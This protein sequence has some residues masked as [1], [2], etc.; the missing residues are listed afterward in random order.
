MRSNRVERCTPR[1]LEW[2]A[3]PDVVTRSRSCVR[4]IR[5]PRICPGRRG[6]PRTTYGS[7]ICPGCAAARSWS[8]RSSTARTPPSTPT[9]CTPGRS[10]RR[11]T[12]RGP[13]SRRCRAGSA[14]A[15]PAGWRVCGENL[16]A[17]HSIAYDGPGE[18]VLRLLGLGRASAAWTGTG[19]C[20]SCAAGRSRAARAVAGR[21]STSGRCA[22]C[23]WTPRGR[24]GTSY[25]PSTASA[26]QEFGRRVAKWVRA[27]HVQTD[28]HW[29]HAAVVR[30]RAGSGRRAVG[31]AVGGGGRR[32]GAAGGG[33]GRTVARGDG[34]DA[35]GRPT[36]R[37]PTL[38]RLDALRPVRGRPAGRACWPPLLHGAPRARL[39]ARLAAAAGHAAG[40][41]GRR[42]GRAAPDAAPAVSRTRTGGPGWYG[43]RSPPT[44]GVLHAVARRRWRPDDAAG[45]RAGRLVRAARRGRRA[46]RR[47]AGAAA[48]RAAGGARRSR[49]GRGR[50]V[51]GRGAARRTR[52]GG[53]ARVEEAVA[54]TWRWRYGDVPP[55]DP[56]GR[57]VGQ[58]QEHLRRAACP[59]VDAY[60]VLDD[61]RAGPGLPGRPAGQRG[62]A[63]R[64]PR[65]ARRRAG[66]AAATV[67]WD[68]TSLNQQQRSPGARGRPPPRRPGHP[69]RGAGRRGGAGPAQRPRAPHP[70]PPR[71]ARPRSCTGSARRTPVRRTA[72]GTSAAGRRRRGHRRRALRRRDGR[73]R[74]AYQ[75]GDLPPGPLGRPVRPGAVRARASPSAGPRPSGS[76]CP[77][78]CPAATS[79][80]T[81]CCSSRRTASWSGTGP[82][83]WTGS[84]PPARGGCAS[85][86]CCGRRSSPP[87]PRTRGTGGRRLAAA[88]RPA[89]ARAAPA[90]RRPLR[91]LTWNTLWDRYD[92]DRHRH[93]PAPA[94]A[95]APP[96]AEA[97]A[98][99]IA[100]QEVEPALL[101]MLLREPLGAGAATRWAPTRR[102]RDV[103]DMRAAAAQPAARTG[104]RA[105]RARPAQGGH[106]RHRGDRRRPAGRRRHPPDQRPLRERCRPA[107]GRTGPARRGAGG[108][109]R[110]SGPAR[111]LQRRRRRTGEPRS[112]CGTPGPRCTAPDDRTP[113]FDPA[114]NPLAAVSSLSGRA[115]RLDRVLVRPGTAAGGPGGAGG[116]RPA[117]RTGC[118]SP[119]TTGSR[120]GSA[121]ARPTRST[122]DARR[123]TAGPADRPAEEPRGAARMA[124]RGSAAALPEGRVHLVGS[125]R[126]GCAPPGAD[127][128]LV[129]ALPGA[130]TAGGPGAGSRP[131][132]R[133]PTRIRA[134]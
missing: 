23:G 68:A 12:P 48:R 94:A 36:P 110:R 112:G 132:C 66:R 63:A 121:S 113:T 69:R 103:D 71:G 10:T 31:G 80:G 54:A 4:T 107:A 67:V 79:R 28:T 131:R 59:G 134:R 91:V 89:A 40:A 2:P 105:A 75:R 72:P 55:A 47:A 64:G 24:R 111:R 17:R 78:S 49:S 82:R 128:D 124:R 104:G 53:S 76:R 6:P 61:L 77:P 3:G 127:L 126:M 16:Y 133:T 26:R 70:V 56:P 108:R 106:R 18:L 52:R 74:D 83:A 46:A 42:P 58:R 60:I 7:P 34:A 44:S 19:P 125:R 9:A 90:A 120:P 11:T 27:G 88:E 15:I 102:G 33:R 39:A 20:V 57:P 81:G 119:T 122:P 51:L 92:A 65:P 93:R 62:R 29:M 5:G 118:T 43:C 101:A 116:R 84:T 117:T 1:C 25:G 123:R 98:D 32:A 129:A 22:R 87:A 41:A 45:A 100:L 37:W 115:S 73:R 8:P 86:A 99:V 50:P 95:A 109:G 114:V 13:G 30:E 21:R 130:V 14:R 97:D 38:A 85:R 35:G 96:C